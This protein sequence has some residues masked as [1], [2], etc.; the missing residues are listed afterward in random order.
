MT[1]QRYQN[2][3]GQWIIDRGGVRYSYATEQEALQAEGEF[4]MDEIYQKFISTVAAQARLLRNSMAQTQELDVLQ[5]GVSAYSTKITQEMIDAVPEFK[6]AGL[7]VG[8]VA[9]TIYVL[10]QANTAL[11]GNLPSIIILANL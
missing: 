11:E 6:A 4:I 7:T 1:N 10:K 9:D 3:S 5:N 8:Q 2:A